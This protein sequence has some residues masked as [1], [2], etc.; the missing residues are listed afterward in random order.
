MKV[1]VVRNPEFEK[2]IEEHF[3][4]YKE[5]YKFI[6]KFKL[7]FHLGRFWKHEGKIPGINEIPEY[8]CSKES[9]M[10]LE[11]YEKSLEILLEKQLNDLLILKNGI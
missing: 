6:E 2:L 1:E 8:S 7:R 5:E 3:K 11:E 9:N 10:S 4:K